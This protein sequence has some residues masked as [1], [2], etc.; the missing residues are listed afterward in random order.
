[1]GTTSDKLQKLL[2]TKENIRQAIINK[3]VNVSESDAF[4]S[5]ATKIS[6]IEIGESTALN[7][8]TVNKLDDEWQFGLITTSSSTKISPSV[9]DYNGVSSFES[10]T[11]PHDWSI[12]QPFNSNSPAS[13]KGGYLDGGY[14]WYKRIINLDASQSSKQIY[15]YFDGIYMTSN[16]YI[17][18]D[19]VKQNYNGYNPFYVD[20]TSHLNFD[21]NDTLSV[22][23]E[24]R[25]PSSRWYSGSGIYR[26]AYLLVCNKVNIGVA[27]IQITTPDLEKE[28]KNTGSV[29]TII[30]MNVINSGATSTSAV[31]KNSIYFNNK[32]INYSFDTLT[33]STGANAFSATVIVG[34]PKLWDVNSPYLYMLKTEITSNNEII[35]SKET[36]FGYRYFKF[37]PNEAFSL[38]GNTIK[39]QGVCLHHDNGCLGAI[40]NKSAIKRKLDLL[41]EM[42]CNSIRTSHNT[43][44]SEFLELASEEGFLV[45]EELF[46]CWTIKKSEYDFAQYF[47]DHY[48]EVIET[49][50]K[51]DR[52]NP[53]I[54]MWSI[55]NEI[56]EIGSNTDKA[57]SYVT[58][59]K[60]CIHQ[61]DTT[62]P[63]TLGDNIGGTENALQTSVL[64][65]VVGFNY[66]GQVAFETVHKNY[67]NMCLYGSETISAVGS[68]GI[69]AHDAENHQCSAGSQAAK[70]YTDARMYYKYPW[71]A[72][73]YIWTGI[74]YIGEPKPFETKSAYPARSSYFGAIDLAGFKKD[75]FYSLKSLWKDEPTVAIIPHTWDGYDSGAEVNLDFYYNKIS[76]IELFING[77]S[78]FKQ[79]NISLND[80]NGVPTRTMGKK[81]TYASGVLVLNG[82]DSKGNLVAQDV[83]R[84]S[85]TP[86][87]IELI[88]DKSTV[89]KDSD[90]LVFVECNILNANGYFCGTATNE[91]TFSVT[92]GTI[93]GTDNGDPTSTLSFQSNI[94]PAFSG[95]ALVVIKPDNNIGKLTITANAEGLTNNSVSVIKNTVTSIKPMSSQVF[96][97]NDGTAKED[98]P[99]YATGISLAQ[100]ELTLKEGNTATLSYSVTPPNGEYESIVFSSNNANATVNS[101]SGLVTAV[102]SGSAIITVTLTVNGNTYT[103]TCNITV[104][105]IEYVTGVTLS[106]KTLNV[107]AGQWSERINYTLTGNEYTSISWENS[108]DSKATWDVYSQKVQGIA[109]GE[110]IITCKVVANG[111][112]YTDTCTVT[113]VKATTTYYSVTNTLTNVTTNNS[114][115]SIVANSNYTATLTPDSGYELSTVTVVMGEVDITNDSYSN[116][117]INIATVT[118]NVVITATATTQSTPGGE[119]SDYAIYLDAS[120]HG[121]DVNVWKDLS[122]N[123]NDVALNGFTH[124]GNT[125]GWINGSLVFNGTTTYGLCDTFKPFSTSSVE[126]NGINF[127]I[128]ATIEFNEDSSATNKYYIGLMEEK[129][130][131]NG[132]CVAITNYNGRQEVIFNLGKKVGNYTGFDA[133]TP[134]NLKITFRKDNNLV[135]SINGVE[136]P[137]AL[138]TNTSNR[139]EQ[140]L[141]LGANIINGAVTRFGKMKLSKFSFKYI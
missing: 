141:Y 21:G 118:G 89:N 5:Y 13:F 101:S 95:K 26:N 77:T 116:G 34:N 22:F 51:R 63:I 65:D 108:D 39:L 17:N 135:V 128:E 37:D 88:A 119:Y 112:T 59:L 127:E 130:P 82:Y 79:N 19:L 100:H 56:Y 9:S 42:G 43:A 83:V 14:A 10:V 84:T 48:Q 68:R 90:D 111:N 137:S 69:Y 133:N 55:G 86:N 67:P 36:K 97:N 104:E 113:V 115:N 15:L 2:T 27:D 92:G 57:T 1:M 58:M 109:A 11:I 139:T 23:V 93:V 40:V 123:G 75:G 98:T 62:R 72:G 53:A 131:W 25:Q 32:L 138:V 136:Q 87:K 38:N 46:D 132:L 120:Q 24:N 70:L 140:P 114:V 106:P 7:V 64:L 71:L 96:V 99:I 12:H 91:I 16:V 18:G 52:N 6:Q 45:M 28:L 121:S 61:Y 44:S 124:D 76:G 60:N 117:V 74:D 125:D 31:I 126:S 29:S 129:N 33:L 30:N 8:N 35:Y 122:G 4:S 107:E 85:G 102:S 105:A 73:Q 41:R 3:G 94:R 66:G 50:I 20:I 49:T 110:T 134:V 54:I 78:V 81:V 80:T 47:D 103:D